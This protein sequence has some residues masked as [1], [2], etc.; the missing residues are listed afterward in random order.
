MNKS[1]LLP[2]SVLVAV[3]LVAGIWYVATPRGPRPPV[4]VFE[5]AELGCRF[6]YPSELWA[7]PNFVRAHSGSLFTIER[8]SLHQ[9]R[10]DFVAALP[11]VLF[12]QVQIQLEESYPGVEELARTPVTIG[13]RRGLEV[14]LRGRASRASSSTRITVDI[15]ATE[16]WVYV[17]RAYSPEAL[18]DAERP[19]FQRVRDTFD[20]L[21]ARG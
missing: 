4:L 11:D 2:L 16:D 10:K 12:Q 5:N 8:H 3:A 19:L 14:T 21:P 13:G 1:F 15:V 20:F 18:H 7:G 17:L 9:A 6:E